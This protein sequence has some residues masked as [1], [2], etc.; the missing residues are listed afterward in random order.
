[1]AAGNAG[2]GA[3]QTI[4]F[5]LLQR[6]ID[7]PS[8]YRS[9]E[10]GTNFEHLWRVQDRRRRA[11]RVALGCQEHLLQVS[12][13]GAAENSPATSRMI[14]GVSQRSGGPPTDGQALVSTCF[15]D[16]AQN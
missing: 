15:E 14:I 16:I 12:G 2:V 7:N 13:H 3:I 1:M 9:V 6:N 10:Q 11:F 4:D 5:D 8:A